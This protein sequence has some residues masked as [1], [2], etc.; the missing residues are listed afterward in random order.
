MNNLG[1]HGK[2]L[3]KGGGANLNGFTWESFNRSSV[4]SLKLSGSV[5][6]R[7]SSVSQKKEGEVLMIFSLGR[8][9]LT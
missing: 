2:G 5:N 3:E 8:A 1:L 6:D 9:G 4:A 7:D